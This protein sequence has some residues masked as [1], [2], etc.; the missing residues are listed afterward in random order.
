MRG[1][2]IIGSFHDTCLTIIWEKCGSR[3]EED[4]W[5]TR[6]ACSKAKEH[7]AAIEKQMAELGQAQALLERARERQH[8]LLKKRDDAE[9]LVCGLSSTLVLAEACD[10]K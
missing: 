10:G 9:A 4:I 5:M 1:D 6:E 7:Q 3:Y 2:E 8:F